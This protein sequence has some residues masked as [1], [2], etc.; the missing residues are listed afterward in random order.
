MFGDV[1]DEGVEGEILLDLA[2]G[3]DEDDGGDDGEDE[4]YI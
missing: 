2:G 1:M 4:D 3:G